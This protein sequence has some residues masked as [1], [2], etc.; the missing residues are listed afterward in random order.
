L[1]AAGVDTLPFTDEQIGT[2]VTVLYD[3]IVTLWAMW[4]NQSVT[5]AALL[6]DKIMSRI[7]TGELSLDEVSKAL[8]VKDAKNG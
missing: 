7:K 5:P 2:A 3:A 4:K 6:A 8:D 1:R